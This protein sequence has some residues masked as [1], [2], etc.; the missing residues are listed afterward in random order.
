MIRLL[1]SDRRG[2]SLVERVRVLVL[3]GLITSAAVSLIGPT[4]ELASEA[5]EAAEVEEGA[6][7]SVNLIASTLRRVTMGGVLVATRD[8][9]VVAMPVGMG[10]FCANDGSRLGAYLGLGGRPLPVA[11]IDG[12]ALREANGTWSYTTYP[13][14]SIFSGASPGRSACIAAGGGQA[15]NDSDYVLF[16]I[17]TSILPGTGFMVWDRQTYRF[18]PSVLDPRTRGFHYGATGGPLLEVAFELHP[19]TR[20]EYR[21]RG[22]TTWYPG[23]SASYVQYIDVVRVIAGGIHDPSGALIAREIPLMNSE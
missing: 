9:V 13:G 10:A 5:T 16:G 23:V 6:R 21:L 4:N 17:S 19:N 15:G 2:A 20:F 14:T 3:G 1:H 22:S 18:G 7:S 11:E 8:S 12:Y